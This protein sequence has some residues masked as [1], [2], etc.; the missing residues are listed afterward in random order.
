ML[1]NV[2]TPRA[3]ARIYV[4]QNCISRTVVTTASTELLDRQAEQVHKWAEEHGWKLELPGDSA[5]REHRR[6]TAPAVNAPDA[7]GGS[8]T[9]VSARSPD[10][11]G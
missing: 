9:R 10:G 2:N 1:L 7:L 11:D 5:E 4:V 6:G 8:C 3:R